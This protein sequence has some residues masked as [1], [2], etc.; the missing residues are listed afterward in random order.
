[1]ATWCARE[2]QRLLRAGFRTRGED[3][4]ASLVLL[5]VGC[6]CVS[7]VARPAS[8]A[9]LDPRTIRSETLGNGLRLVVASDADAPAV[10]V[11]VIVRAGAADDPPGQR[12]TAHLLEHVLWARHSGRADDP[13]LRIE[14]VGGMVD[15]GTLRDYTRFYVAVPAGSMEL[16]IAA[17]AHILLS[18]EFDEAVVDRERAIV[19][20][21]CA[22]RAESARALLNDLAFAELYGPD[23][24]YAAP[25][26][27]TE[28]DL[29]TVGSAR[30]ALF[31]E[32]WY[33][34]NNMAVMVCGDV[35]FDAAREAV[36]NA[37][38]YLLPAAVPN[39][40]WAVPS[41]P[42]KARQRVVDMPIEKAYVM[43]AFVGP[44][45]SEHAQVCASDLLAALLTHGPSSRL[46]ERLTQSSDLALEV[47]VDF[48][49]QRD[50]SLFGVWAVCS[51]ERIDDVKQAIAAE[52][53]RLAREALPAA[54]FAMAK[55]LLAAGY[56]FAN[57]TTSDRATTLGFYEAI[58]TYRI[59]SYYLSWVSYAR[60]D[61]LTE[62]AHWYS[63]EPVWIILRPKGS[64]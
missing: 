25:V 44:D 51:P 53:K 58:D 15:A 32:S 8:A 38:G 13:R 9:V 29:D 31:H 2:S 24:P 10:A 45:V 62:V 4:W 63:A 28:A 3:A 14:R 1:M 27:G 57:E 5:L 23:H 64:Q 60:S 56:A 22:V 20:E 61:V 40:A 33:V 42:A 55:R 43:A 36:N 11:E 46:A 7:A 18:P 21:E 41:R 12:G 37:F 34:P 17:L 54:E 16:A 35:S 50:R 6:A 49:T 19:L 52:M 59:A 39:R 26:C 47:G 30:L 48:L